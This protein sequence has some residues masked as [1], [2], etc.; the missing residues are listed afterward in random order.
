MK[1]FK[2][3]LHGCALAAGFYIICA[4]TLGGVFLALYWLCAL[5][6]NLLGAL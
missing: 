1:R 2:D 4:V 3:S 5:V 6:G